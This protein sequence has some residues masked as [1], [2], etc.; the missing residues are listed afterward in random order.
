MNNGPTTRTAADTE[1]VTCCVCHRAGQA[2]YRMDPFV[3]VRC[4]GCSMVFLSPRLHARGRQRFY[5][6]VGYFEGGVYGGKNP[7]SPAMVW[8]RIWAS[9]RLNLIAEDVRARSGK[10]PGQCHLLEVGAAY[11]QFLDAARRRGYEV[12]GVELSRPAAGNA[13]SELG[14]DVRQGELESVDLPGGYDVIC[15]WDTIEHVADPVSFVRRVADLLSGDGVVAFSTPYFSS[16][17]ARLFKTR[18]W[19][20]KPAEHIWHF[21]PETHRLVFAEA[22]LRVSRLVRN[23]LVRANASRTDS[24]VGLAHRSP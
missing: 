23:P 21:T 19:N 9:G 6:D 20:L 15:A 24:L 16:V 14:L 10:E 2:V 3:V 8:Q 13:R 7:W 4:P 22:G 11:G 1:E 12:T 17:P 5:D 18:W